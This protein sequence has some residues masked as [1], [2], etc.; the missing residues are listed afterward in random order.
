MPFFDIPCD[1]NAWT[2]RCDCE[3]ECL[4]LASPDNQA[5]CIQ[6]CQD[7]RAGKC[8]QCTTTPDPSDG[9]Y[10]QCS[11]TYNSGAATCEAAFTEC[12]TTSSTSMCAVTYSACR[13]SVDR[14]LVDCSAACDQTKVRFQGNCQIAEAQCKRELCETD[15]DWYSQV[16]ARCES[17]R[18]QAISNTDS[19]Y[20][21]TLAGCDKTSLTCITGCSDDFFAASLACDGKCH[22]DEDCRSDCIGAASEAEDHC[23][24]AC[25]TEQSR[26]QGN[27][28]A[29][30]ASGLASADAAAVLCGGKAAVDQIIRTDAGAER[31]KV[32][33]RTARAD[34]GY[35]TCATN[36]R[37][38]HIIA[39]AAAQAAR[40]KC[41]STATSPDDDAACA[42][43]YSAASREVTLAWL[44]AVFECCR[45]KAPKDSYA[46]CDIAC[47]R[48]LATCTGEDC[49]EVFIAC[50]NRCYQSYTDL[51]NTLSRNFMPTLNMER[52]C[53]NCSYL[54][55]RTVVLGIPDGA[56]E[57]MAWPIPPT[58][59]D[60]D[61]RPAY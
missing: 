46:D 57:N 14:T 25:T 34:V 22:D 20:Y 53:W 23:I 19:S 9:C 41:E 1:F 7:E 42:D 56:Y 15:P 2:P 45:Q 47:L 16:V 51:F 44:N 43:A 21:S 32:R 59:V 61:I 10:G 39:A 5:A 24:A 17:D 6:R 26:C 18:L 60:G 58:A 55:Q 35:V 37:A 48:T 4:R 29:S 11:D 31:S 50:R 49:E 33:F 12:L 36:A 30:R 8:R 28:A 52:S 3:V 38:A 54:A 40:V 27:A 13:L